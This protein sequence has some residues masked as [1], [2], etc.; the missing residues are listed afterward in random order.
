[1]TVCTSPDCPSEATVEGKFSWWC[2]DHADILA[3]ARKAIRK[4]SGPKPVVSSTAKGRGEIV[5]A[6]AEKLAAAA[7]AGNGVKLDD[8]A[9]LTGLGAG[10]A[11]LGDS[12]SLAKSKG[13]LRVEDGRLTPGDKPA[14]TTRRPPRVPLRER[15][16][17]LSESVHAA[18]GRWLSGP[19]AAEAVGCSIHALTKISAYARE[20][21]W[22]TSKRG[23]PGYSAGPLAPLAH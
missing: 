9:T 2:Q 22:I 5:K 18:E 14:T 1:M 15:A 13:W 7:S 4:K 3:A 17:L 21:E 23:V 12:I 19:D 20:Q 6:A 10:S 11:A 16:R 8:A